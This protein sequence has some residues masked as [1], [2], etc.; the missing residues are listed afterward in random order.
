M[1]RKSQFNYVDFSKSQSFK[2]SFLMSLSSLATRSK[3][4]FL[5][6]RCVFRNEAYSPGKQNKTKQNAL[7]QLQKQQ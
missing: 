4:I 3:N 6:L 5:I 7:I 1:L 2:D